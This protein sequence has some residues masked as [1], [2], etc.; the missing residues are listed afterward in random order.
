MDFL[1]I[2]SR[3]ALTQPLSDQPDY[4]SREFPSDGPEET[5]SKVV[6]KPGKDEWCVKSEKNPDWNGGCYPS[7]GKAEKRL[8]QVEYFK[9]NGSEDLS[10]TISPKGKVLVTLGGE[11]IGGISKIE[12]SADASESFPKIHVSFLDGL[13]QESFDTMDPERRGR[14]LAA[15]DSLRKFLI[16]TVSVPTGSDKA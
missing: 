1:R 16:A 5:V 14:I 8:H 9:H 4:G 12:I 15:A 11:L 7:K 10:V 3:V 2:A 13:S 6:K